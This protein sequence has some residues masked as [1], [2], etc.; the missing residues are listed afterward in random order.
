MTDPG[1]L[2]DPGHPALSGRLRGRPRPRHGHVCTLT[3]APIVDLSSMVELRLDPEAA[4][5]FD[6]SAV[7]ERASPRGGAALPGPNGLPPRFPLLLRFAGLSA[8]ARW[9]ASRRDSGSDGGSD[10][11][12]DSG[13]DGDASF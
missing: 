1:Q 7:T 12:S 10:S 4:E 5:G 13:S 9:L 6:L 8:L 2:T 11:G 3:G